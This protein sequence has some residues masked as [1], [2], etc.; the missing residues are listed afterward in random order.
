MSIRMRTTMAVALIATSSCGVGA[1]SEVVTSNGGILDC[2]S[3]TIEYAH[4][5]RSFEAPGSP[6]PG[7]ATPRHAA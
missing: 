5:D 1:R 4:F 6:T 7:G 3:G 2:P